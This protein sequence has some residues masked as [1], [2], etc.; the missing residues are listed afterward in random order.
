[1]RLNSMTGPRLIRAGESRVD[2]EAIAELGIQPVAEDPVVPE[3]GVV[4]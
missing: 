3:P 2:S 1:M 4:V